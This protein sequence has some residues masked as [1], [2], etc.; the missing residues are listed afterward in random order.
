MLSSAIKRVFVCWVRRLRNW[1]GIGGVFY[2]FVSITFACAFFIAGSDGGRQF[3]I[4]ASSNYNLN[5]FK[6]IN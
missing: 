3:D 4:W 6:D 1:L 2:P 5:N